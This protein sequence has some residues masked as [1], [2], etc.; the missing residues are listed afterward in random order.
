MA[1]KNGG[2]FIGR[3]GHHGYGGAE[4]FRLVSCGDVNVCVDFGGRISPG[5]CA[6]DSCRDFLWV[7][8]HLPGGEWSFFAGMSD[9]GS[10]VRFVS[11]IGKKG[12]PDS[13]FVRVYFGIA[14][15]R[16][17]ISG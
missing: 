15:R 14:D 9:G 1:G 4:R 3:I 13:V 16:T 6:G 2:I 12:K 17:D 10:V 7:G 5:N 11:P 8:T